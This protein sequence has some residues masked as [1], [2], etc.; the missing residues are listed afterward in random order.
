MKIYVLCSQADEQTDVIR[1]YLHED[2]AVAA[3]AELQQESDKEWGCR[4]EE[5]Y[6]VQ[7][8]LVASP[9]EVRLASGF[10]FVC[11]ICICCF[12][13]HHE[14]CHSGRLSALGWHARCACKHDERLPL[15]NP[16][17]PARLPAG[18]CHL[19]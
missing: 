7:R 2:T 15:M 3:G 10:E 19:V 17:Q 5:F 9:T 12:E 18:W 6:V 11:G 1:T 13:G 14:N 8:D 16:E 4:F